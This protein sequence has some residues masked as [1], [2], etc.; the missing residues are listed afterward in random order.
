MSEAPYLEIKRSQLSRIA[1][2]DTV[3]QIRCW[4]P[5]TERPLVLLHGLRD[6]SISFQFL[7]D[8][9]G[10]PWRVIAP[11]WRGHGGTQTAGHAGA[12]QDYLADMDVLLE[13]LFDRRPVDVVGHSIG[14]NL[15]TAYA[16]L[17]PQRIAR[18]IALD[19]FGALALP[20]P[21]FLDSVENWLKRGSDEPPAPIG[22]PSIEQMAASLCRANR[23]LSP[24]RAL[25]LAQHSSRTLAGGGHAWCF[26]RELRHS[27]PLLRTTE[28]W[29]ACWAR[30]ACPALWLAASEPRVGTVAADPTTMS[31]VR[32]AIGNLHIVSIPE[33]GHNLHHDDPEGIA[34]LIEQFLTQ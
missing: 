9:F 14:G 21:V 3:Y 34:K 4:G 16:G 19:A 8:A 20:P 24:A 12:F 7:V 27:V 22:Y 10:G 15:A 30:I 25:F 11:D 26:D 29:I 5:T 33:T 28:E 18:V 13:L 2:R 23:R 31:R 6:S 1:V 32:A 17:R